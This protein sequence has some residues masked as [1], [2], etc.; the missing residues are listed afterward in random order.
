MEAAVW[1]DG[2]AK[3]WLKK[4]AR[5]EAMEMVRVYLGEAVAVNGRVFVE[6]VVRMGIRERGGG[7]MVR[8][9]LGEA[10]T[11]NG[12][13]FVDLVARMEIRE[14]GGGLCMKR[15]DGQ[16]EGVEVNV[17]GEEGKGLVKKSRKG[18][19]SENG[20]LEVN[21]GGSWFI[22]ISMLERDA[23]VEMVRV[24]LGEMIA[25]NGPMFVEMVGK[26][27]VKKSRKVGGSENGVLEVNVVGSWFI[28]M[29]MLERDARGEAVAVNGPMFVE[30]VVRMEIREGGGGLCRKRGDGQNEG[31]EV[32]VG[33]GEGK[34][35]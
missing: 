8:V 9:C 21:V 10:I 22:L 4:N 24:Y 12:M 6:M 13:M 17:G 15:R 26:G 1:D 23:R 5:N 19:V 25:V 30:M 11:V 28:L 35:L 32:N 29:S 34:G 2:V 14:R 18:G 20:V 16:N 27:L 33:G 3:R 31:V 7:K